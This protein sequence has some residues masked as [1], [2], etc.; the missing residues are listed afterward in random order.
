M[1]GIAD[2]WPA[3]ATA[4]RRPRVVLVLMVA[5]VICSLPSLTYN[6]LYVFTLMD[7]NVAGHILLLTCLCFCIATWCNALRVSPRRRHLDPAQTLSLQQI[8][9]KAPPSPPV[10][11][12][13]PV[14]P[15]TPVQIDLTNLTLQTRHIPPTQRWKCGKDGWDAMITNVERMSSLKLPGWARVLL[16]EMW[17]FV[18]P[19]VLVFVLV[20]YLLVD[21]LLLIPSAKPEPAL[22][23]FRWVLITG[24]L[25]PFAFYLARSFFVWLLYKYHAVRHTAVV[26]VSASTV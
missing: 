15:A 1:S 25:L 3:L 8:P 17:R 6:G 11:P 13:P 26:H 23:P 10:S 19:I 24:P 9:Q 2:R 7:M 14:P 22:H 21:V 18:A 5:V 12:P 16:R 20:C 4:Q